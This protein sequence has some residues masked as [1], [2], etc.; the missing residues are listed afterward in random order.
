M[1][2]KAGR[3][4]NIVELFAK[5]S[6]KDLSDKADKTR[7]DLLYHNWGG[8]AVRGLDTDIHNSKTSETG[9]MS[10]AKLVRYMRQ[11]KLRTTSDVIQFLSDKWKDRK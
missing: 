4:E 9:S 8:D 1:Q 6:I 11:Y 5:D 3:V 10:I 2:E 7:Y